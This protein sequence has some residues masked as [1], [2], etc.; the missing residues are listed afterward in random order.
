MRNFPIEEHVIRSNRYKNYF[1]NKKHIKELTIEIN[2]FTLLF[3][4]VLLN[5]YA[6]TQT[7]TQFSNIELK[8]NKKGNIKILGF[9]SCSYNL[10]PM[11]DFV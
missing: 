3:F 9:E 2:I 1:K 10:P 8:V 5:I 11:P 6:Q 7:Q 4:S